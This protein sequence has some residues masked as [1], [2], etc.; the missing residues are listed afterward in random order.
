MADNSEMVSL[1][2]FDL[3]QERDFWTK[4]ESFDSKKHSKVVLID[5]LIALIHKSDR[6]IIRLK[7]IRGLGKIAFH[8]RDAID[9][10]IH[11][12]LHEQT[13]SRYL[14]A[15]SLS[16]IAIG[17]RIAINSLVEIIYRSQDIV[18]INCIANILC[19]IAVN[20]NKAIDALI[21]LLR[22][23]YDLSGKLIIAKKLNKISPNHSQAI[24][25]FLDIIAR[26]N[27]YNLRYEAMNYLSQFKTDNPI[28]IDE[29]QRIA[30]LE[31]EKTSVVEGR[32]IAKIGLQ[33]INRNWFYKIC[34]TINFWNKSFKH[35]SLNIILLAVFSLCYI[36]SVA[37]SI[38]MFIISNILKLF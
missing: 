22:E 35:F 13:T 25:A 9:T 32:K 21:Y 23:S 27:D 19:N 36:L 33:N 29:F 14:A 24:A 26:G 18:E 16:K 11:V 28:V 3:I 4:I 20:N 34:K 6:K 10:L 8:N 30:R 12:L 15:E 37:K 7:A 17:D 1:H 31:G 2:D 5:T 38:A